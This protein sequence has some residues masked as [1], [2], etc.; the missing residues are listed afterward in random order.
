MRKNC[1][2]L[3]LI[4]A[5]LGSSA[6]SATRLRRQAANGD[7]EAQTKS[8]H[9]T[10]LNSGRGGLRG[11][12]LFNII[13]ISRGYDAQAHE[14]LN[15]ISENV[16]LISEIE[17][18]GPFVVGP[19]IFVDGKMGRSGSDLQGL[20]EESTKR[21]IGG[22]NADPH[23]FHSMLLLRYGG[24]WRWAGCG[25]TLV[26]NCHV[27]TAAHCAADPTNPLGAVFVNAHR[28]YQ[29]NL[30]LPF[31]FSPV[32]HVTRHAGYNST[33]NAHD[34]AVVKMA[35]CLDTTQFPPAIPANPD[36]VLPSD[37]M[38]DILGFGKL[39]EQGNLFENT[40][41]LQIAHVPI[42]PPDTCKEYYGEKIKTDMFCGG[43]A[44][45]GI[46][47]CQGDSGS[48]MTYVNHESNSTVL[49]GVVSWGVGCGRSNSPG[50]YSSVQYHYGWLA[51]QICRDADTIAPWCS[52]YDFDAPTL[53]PTAAPTVVSQDG[54]QKDEKDKD[55]NKEKEEKEKDR[56][57]ATFY[58][59]PSSS[60]AVTINRSYDTTSNAHVIASAPQEEQPNVQFWDPITSHSVCKAS[61]SECRWG[62]ECCSG[63]CQEASLNNGG[64]KL[65]LSTNDS[66]T[67]SSNQRRKETHGVR[68][69]K[70]SK[71]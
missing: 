67:T 33:N 39:S 55:K 53:A 62:D 71:H 14:D 29:E 47:A 35:Q 34:I 52:T 23:P 44:M 58:A 11:R 70:R 63:V 25:A 15:S 60:T 51:R 49:I 24:S 41:A 43:Y 36:L 45:G 40:Q 69:T 48:S 26:S 28:P 22:R 59:P 5:L 7:D 10:N 27:V 68:V 9:L 54:K 61:G 4:T 46:D 8:N 32:E 20:E 65:C 56:T 57:S 1:F 42:I 3:S 30:G 31:H 13:D 37:L 18:G 64:A 50:V 12:G 17:T 2:L 38:A 6:T 21:I 16:E 66:I 19:E